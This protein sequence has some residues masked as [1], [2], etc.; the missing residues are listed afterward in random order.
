[1]RPLPP[2]WTIKPEPCVGVTCLDAKGRPVSQHP[3]DTDAFRGLCWS[4][5]RQ[6]YKESDAGA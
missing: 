5:Y 6:E 1:M 2:G 3:A 4:I